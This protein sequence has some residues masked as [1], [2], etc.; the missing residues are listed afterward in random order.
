MEGKSKESKCHQVKLILLG[1]SGVGKTTI[2][3][4]FKGEQYNEQHSP[5]IG[6][7]FQSHEVKLADSDTVKFQIW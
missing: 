4:R 1:H 2:A 3:N 5:S 7:S 6:V